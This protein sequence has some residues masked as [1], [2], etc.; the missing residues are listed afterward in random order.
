MSRTLNLSEHLLAE[1]RKYQNL[2]VDD[3]AQRIFADLARLRDLPAH[4][5]E[6]TQ[7][8]LAE[9]LL[10]QRKFAR[11]RRHLAAALTYDGQNPIYH[12]LM[13]VALEE[14]SKGDR[15]LA[16]RH[17]RRCVQLEPDE[18]VYHCDAGL[19][20]LKHGA[21]DEGLS[22]LRRAVE[23]APDNVDIIAEVV[24]G[25][26]DEG[27]HDEARQIAKAALFR[28]SSDARFQRLWNDSR[29]QEIHQQQ[30]RANRKRLVRRAVAE[31]RIC[32]PFMQMTVETPSGRKLVRTDGPSRTPPPHLLRFARLSGKK[33]A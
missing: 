19:F 31:G 17:Y 8:R 15:D 28:N 14:D 16:L 21:V 22:Y 4:V 27:H 9:L 26:Q 29:F 5:S 6:E 10:K 13:A 23:L 1:G 11:A 2:G 7:C 33:H 32:L 30:Q 18:P 25:L 20:A 12:H 3:R 24:R